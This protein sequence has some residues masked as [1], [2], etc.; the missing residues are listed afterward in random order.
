MKI[1]SLGGSTSSQ[2]INRQ[3][4]R[5][6]AGLVADGE[7]TDL[8][9]REFEL[10]LFSVDEEEANGVPQG[11]KDFLALIDQHDA[12]V[13]SLAEHNGSYTAAFKNL[14][15]WA[16][17][18]RYEVWG[19]KP[20]LLMATSPGGRGG[21]GVLAAAEATFPRMGA[22]LRATFSLP[23]FGDNFDSEAGVSDEAL[24]AKLDEAVS[25]L[26]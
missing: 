3:L 12:L 17:R 7:V 9:L 8:D 18:E 1:L 5:Y 25:R 23:G 11:A 16:S 15:D 20:M 2:S 19:G 6:A 26:G 10:P 21:A 4:A 14:Y 13:V 22:D 24:K